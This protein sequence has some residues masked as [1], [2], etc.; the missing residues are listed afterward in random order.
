MATPYWEQ[1]GKCHH[2]GTLAP[3]VCP[4]CGERAREMHV[5]TVHIFDAVLPFH[6]PIRSWWWIALESGIRLAPYVPKDPE[7]WAGWF[8]Q[9]FKLRNPVL[10][11]D[12]H[13][14]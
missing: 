7:W 8:T 12:G 11:F 9:S 2:P 13:R 10:S 14:G 1:P 3:N 6:P 5:G 4:W